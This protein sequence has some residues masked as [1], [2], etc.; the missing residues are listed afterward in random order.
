MAC[1]LRVGVLPMPYI[2]DIKLVNGTLEVTG[3]TDILISSVGKQLNCSLC[4][5]AGESSAADGQRR[6]VVGHRGSHERLLR[7]HARLPLGDGRAAENQH[8]GGHRR[9]ALSQGLHAQGHVCWTHLR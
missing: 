5:N 9:E 4:S 1:H 3:V 8:A 2:C 7:A 6:L